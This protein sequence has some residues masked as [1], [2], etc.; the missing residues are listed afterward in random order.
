MNC[1]KATTESCG[2]R[3]DVFETLRKRLELRALGFPLD[4]LASSPTS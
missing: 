3:D 4:Q 2:S 1:F